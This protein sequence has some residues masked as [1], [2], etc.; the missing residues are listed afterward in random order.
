MRFK[1]FLKKHN[2]RDQKCYLKKKK[3]K[4]KIHVVMCLKALGLIFLKNICRKIYIKRNETNDIKLHLLLAL[5]NKPEKYQMQRTGCFYLKRE[6]KIVEIE[7]FLRI[8]T[9]ARKSVMYRIP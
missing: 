2:Y 3:K 7:N 5:V 6:Q 4:K 1:K 9:N 8:V